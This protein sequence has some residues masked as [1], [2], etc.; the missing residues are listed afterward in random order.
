GMVMV[1]NTASAAFDGMPRNA[2]ATGVVDYELPPPEMAAQLIAHVSHAF[3]K[4]PRIEIL[5]PPKVESALK[6]I[7][8]LVR[9][10]TGHDFSLYKP[11]TIHRRID[12]RMAQHQIATIEGYV[13]YLQQ[14]PDEVQAL[15]HDMLIG[16]TSFFRDPAAFQVLASR[17]IPR[18]FEN[19]HAGVPIRV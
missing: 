10:E 18:L 3:G 1:Q 13:R 15:F 5:T 2:I 7:F 12:R 17:V 9:T 4:L 19:Q 8:I 16:V 14:T 6:K 11:A